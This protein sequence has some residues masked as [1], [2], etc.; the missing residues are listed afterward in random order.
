M[1]GREQH[2]EKHAT[3]HRYPELFRHHFGAASAGRV[4]PTN[5]DLGHE[6]KYKLKASLDAG[7]PRAPGVI[8]GECSG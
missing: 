2:Q 3:E 4:S 5:S 8:A 7:F 1:K 6:F